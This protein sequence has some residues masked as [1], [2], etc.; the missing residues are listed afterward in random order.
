LPTAIARQTRGRAA[1]RRIALAVA[2]KANDIQVQ[3]NAS[4][5]VGGETFDTRS[6]PVT[7]S[8]RS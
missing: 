3:C 6:V 5:K 8:E 7:T 4:R 2:T 1:H